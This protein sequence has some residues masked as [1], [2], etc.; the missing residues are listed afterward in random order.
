MQVMQLVLGPSLTGE[1]IVGREA[2]CWVGEMV[3]K[4]DSM[5]DSHGPQG[6]VR[7]IR[8]MDGSVKHHSPGDGHDGPDGSLSFAIVVMGTNACKPDDLF[9]GRQLLGKG[10]SCEGL[11]IV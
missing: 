9:E 8:P 10:L 2:S 1:D 6:W 3:V 11:A 4:E 7:C 5:P